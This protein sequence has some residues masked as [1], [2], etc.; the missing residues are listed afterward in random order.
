M[1]TEILSGVCGLGMGVGVLLMF[2]G[3]ADVISHGCIGRVALG[4][5]IGCASAIGLWLL[6]G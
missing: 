6:L 5:A 1:M 4:L 2:A 3:M